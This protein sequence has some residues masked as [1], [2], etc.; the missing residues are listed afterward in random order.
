M[1]GGEWPSEEGSTDT[2]TRVSLET[3]L[4]EGSQAQKTETLVPF[5]FNVQ[6]RKSIE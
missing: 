6:D 3:T 4:S 1:W 5:L 2:V